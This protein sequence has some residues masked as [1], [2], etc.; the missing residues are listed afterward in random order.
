[1]VCVEGIQKQ[2]SQSVGRFLVT[3][4]CSRLDVLATLGSNALE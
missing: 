1:M 3:S 4:E 2:P